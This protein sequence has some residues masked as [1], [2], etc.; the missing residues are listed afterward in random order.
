M[1]GLSDYEKSAAKSHNRKKLVLGVMNKLI[2]QPP[3]GMID[4]HLPKDSK[5]GGRRHP[6]PLMTML[7]IHLMQ[8]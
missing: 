5:K 4:K 3:L 7:P 6:C 2:R 1:L 8:L